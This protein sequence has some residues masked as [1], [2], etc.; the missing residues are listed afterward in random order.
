[1]KEGQKALNN[2]EVSDCESMFAWTL[3]KHLKKPNVEIFARCN[4]EK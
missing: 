4:S 2:S 1:M 3:A